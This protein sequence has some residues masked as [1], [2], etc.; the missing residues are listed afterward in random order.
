MKYRKVRN[1]I[2][3]LSPQFKLMERK[4]KQNHYVYV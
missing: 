2:K 3:I 4:K 1:I